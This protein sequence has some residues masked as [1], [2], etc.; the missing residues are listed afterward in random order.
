MPD[1]LRT[2][3]VSQRPFLV[4]EW[5]RSLLERMGLPLPTLCSDERHRRRLSYRNDRRIFRRTCE[6]SGKPI[7]SAYSPDSPCRVYAP[8]SWWGDGWNPLDYARAV[9]FTRPFLE[10]V[11]DLRR[12]VPRLALVNVNGENS[13]YCLNTLNN[14]NCYLVFGGDNNEDCRYGVLN[15]FCRDAADVYWVNRSELVYDC[16]D[17]HGCYNVLYSQNAWSC[18]DSA[19]L[20]ECRSC[21]Y[22]V[23]CV[24]LRFAK[25]CLF[26]EQLSPE[27]WKAAVERLELHRASGVD[28][29]RD[30]FSALKRQFP[31]RHAFLMQA[32]DC[33]GDYITR[34]KNCVGCFNVEGPAEDMKDV[35]F[36]G[37]EGSKNLLSTN[38]VGIRTE[39]HYETSYCNTGSNCAF[40]HYA[41]STS[42]A[43]YCDLVMHSHDLFGCVG[44]KRAEYCVLNTPYSRAEYFALR[45]RVIEHMK[46]TGEWGEFFPM[47]HSPWA[48][49]E[50]AAQDFYPLAKERALELG[51]RWKDEERLT[52]SVSD[53]LPD[54]IEDV[55]DAIMKR[56]LVC[57]RTGRPYKIIPQELAFYRK[58]GIPLPRTAPETRHEERLAKRNPM[59]L[60]NRLCDRCGDEL[61]STYA[62]ERSETV[63]CARCFEAFI[64]GAQ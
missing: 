41:W 40:C 28:A 13:E 27:Q 42:N 48:Y 62:P 60:Y 23:G 32:E 36:G 33:T 11:N 24:G 25:Y 6:L 64:D 21:E 29:A 7:V 19:F 49:N 43:L 51:L 55:D 1:L 44:M 34:A 3:R 16:V 37:W 58:L 26:N 31:H 17:C 50:T 12:E 53:E 54:S 18:R 57:E 59:R 8:E 30:R 5:E 61:Q 14:K 52:R 63:Y 15:M 22:C 39:M 47:E 45:E 2:C 4:T 10:Q 35:I 46:E 56:V 38:N 20:Y 9:D